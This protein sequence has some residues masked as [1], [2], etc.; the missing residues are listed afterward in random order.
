MNITKKSITFVQ[1]VDQKLARDNLFGMVYLP[2]WAMTL[3]AHIKHFIPNRFD[4]KLYDQ[5]ISTDVT[6]EYAH[7]FLFSGINQDIDAIISYKQKLKKNYPDSIFILG[8]PICWSYKTAGRLKDLEEFDYLFIGDAEKSLIDFLKNEIDSVENKRIIESDKKFTLSESLIMDTNL[9][10]HNLKKYYGGVIEVSRG[11]PFLCEFCDI[12]IQKDNNRSNNKTIDLILSEIE[13]FS[14]NGIKQILLACDNFI[15]DPVWAENVCDKIIEWK[16]K[17]GNEV[18]LYTWLTI[19][20]ASNK[21]LLKKMRLAGFDMFFI[22][23]ESFGKNQLLETAKIQNFRISLKECIETIQSFGFIV[24]A[25]IIFGFDTDPD[26]VHE[27][28]LEGIKDCGLISGDPS[29]LTALPGTPLYKRMKYAGRLRE[30]KLGL[31]GAKYCTNIKYLKKS[32]VIKDIFLNFVKEFNSGDFQYSRLINFYKCIDSSNFSK[33]VSGQS[34]VSF[35]SSLKLVWSNWHAITSFIRRFIILIRNPT[36]LYFL[37][38]AIVAT[39]AL[40]RK[41]MIGWSYLF[42]WI[43]N[44]SNSLLKYGKLEDNDFDI[45]SIDS[46]PTKELLIPDEYFQDLDEPIP[47]T[48][49]KSQRALTKK[50][51]TAFL[52]EKID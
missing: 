4:L 6:P 16:E 17:S 43:F 23:I 40:N 38:K 1:V 11:C 13:F 8:G 2:V 24:V 10:A 14:N 29:L 21:R 39:V 44:W 45:D 25:G 9:V 28:T 33:S 42:F 18:N 35:W 36:R 26:N 22:G 52:A 7:Y 12:R 47:M 3:S 37:S 48:K 41:L 31:G 19:N 32:S 15:G 30:A 5:R 34:Y 20:L 49:I 27:I 51:L 46:L 50:S